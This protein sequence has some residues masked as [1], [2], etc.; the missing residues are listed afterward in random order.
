VNELIIADSVSCLKSGGLRLTISNVIAHVNN[1]RQVVANDVT[2]KDV[3]EAHK[4][5]LGFA[6]LM[7]S[8]LLLLV[9]C[10]LVVLWTIAHATRSQVHAH[11]Y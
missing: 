10:W 5:A 9:A 2:R 1:A 8:R 7:V 6:K 4:A 11:A 3:Q